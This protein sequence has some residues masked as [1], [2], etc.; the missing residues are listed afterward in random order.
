MQLDVSSRFGGEFDHILVNMLYTVLP[1]LSCQKNEWVP[2]VLV[3]VYQ[4]QDSPIMAAVKWINAIYWVGG[5]WIWRGSG[6]GGDASSFN[7]A[8]DIGVTAAFEHVALRCILARFVCLLKVAFKLHSGLWCLIGFSC[9]TQ[10]L[11]KHFPTIN[12]MW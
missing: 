9:T 5:G 10:C 8:S 12:T 7:R 4:L 3:V 2:E 11:K 1:R 6:V